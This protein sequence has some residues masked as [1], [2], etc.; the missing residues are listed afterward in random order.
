MGNG[1]LYEVAYGEI[2][3]FCNF[4][5]GSKQKCQGIKLYNFA[6]AGTNIADIAIGC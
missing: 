5:E 1:Q 4:S 3:F 6:N 2:D